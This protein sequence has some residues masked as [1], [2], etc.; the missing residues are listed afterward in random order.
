MALVIQIPFFNDPVFFVVGSFQRSVTTLEHVRAAVRRQI[1]QIP[2][3]AV[4][5]IFPLDDSVAGGIVGQGFIC[6]EKVFQGDLAFIVEEIAMKEIAVIGCGVSVQAHESNIVAQAVRGIGFD[7]IGVIRFFC[8][9][10]AAAGIIPPGGAQYAE[11]IV[12][13]VDF[14]ISVGSIHQMPA[15]VIGVDLCDL[16][17]FVPCNLLVKTLGADNGNIVHPVA[18]INDIAAFVAEANLTRSKRI[19]R[20]LSVRVQID[21]R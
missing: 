1:A 12:I 15:D 8:L 6:V 18:L 14:S 4:F 2:A 9:D 16:A 10:E 19:R 5:V 21:F 20:L 17:G 13:I 11:H 7:G 3:V